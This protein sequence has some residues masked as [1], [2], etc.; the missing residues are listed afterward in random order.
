MLLRFIYYKGFHRFGLAFARNLFVASFL[1]FHSRALCACLAFPPLRQFY[2]CRSV[3]KIN[4]IC[5]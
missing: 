3:L 4:K 2:K 1:S 5:A